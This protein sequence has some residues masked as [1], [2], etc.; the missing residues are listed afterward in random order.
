MPLG[1]PIRGYGVMMLLAVVAGTLLAAWRAKRVGLDPDLIFSLI[2][3]MLVPGIIGARAFYVIEYWAATTG[4][5]YYAGPG[6]SLGALVGAIVNVTKGGLV[7]YGSFFGGVLGMLLFIRKHRLPLLALCDLMAPSMLLGLAIGRIGCLLNGCCFGAVC[8]Q[9]WAIQFPAGTPPGF[10]VPYGD[11]LDHD[12]SQRERGAVL[13]HLSPAYHAQ[14][15]RGQ[16]YGFTLSGDPD[17]QPCVVLGVI[18]DTPAAA[19]GLKAGDRLASINGYSAATTN[20]GAC[21][22]RGGVPR[23]AAA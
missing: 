3:W 5:N 13:T 1:L 15:D 22:D 4:A 7:V 2:F 17:T 12:R 19:A 21:G 6:G 14:L 9:P 20:G 18:A 23:R 10:S 8:D 16:M 11:R